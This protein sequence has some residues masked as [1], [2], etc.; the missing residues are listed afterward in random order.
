MIIEGYDSLERSSVETRRDSRLTLMQ[1]LRDGSSNVLATAIE[2]DP[3]SSGGSDDPHI[4]GYQ[5]SLEYEESNTPEKECLV[6]PYPTRKSV[7]FDHQIVTD[8]VFVELPPSGDVWY[9]PNEFA[10]ITADLQSR[11]QEALH[12]H[13]NDDHN[14]G[15]NDCLYNTCQSEDLLGLEDLISPEAFRSREHRIQTVKQSVLQEQRRQQLSNSTTTKDPIKLSLLSMEVSKDAQ[16]LAQRR[17]AIHDSTLVG[18]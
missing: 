9:S 4:D 8:V 17:A 11:V 12:L 14:N 13:D 18:S 3:W 15:N 5:I 2:S 10:D 6:G 1:H 16:D 7:R